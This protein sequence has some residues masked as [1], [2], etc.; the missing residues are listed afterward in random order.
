MLEGDGTDDRLDQ[1]DFEVA[2][3]CSAEV[4]MS[5]TVVVVSF[6]LPFVDA[7]GWGF[8]KPASEVVL[9]VFLPEFPNPRPN[10]VGDTIPIV[11]AMLR[12]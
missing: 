12:A 5:E 6:F 9:S 11:E 4:D 3:C 7:E 8:E 2:A 1:K 10:D